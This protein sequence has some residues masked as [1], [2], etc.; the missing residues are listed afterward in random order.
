MCSGRSY[1]KTQKIIYSLRK[2]I[3]DIES[4]KINFSIINIKIDEIDWLNLSH[5]GHERM[6]ISFFKKETHFNWVA[7]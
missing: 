3:P 6:I 4:G 7:P 5:K 1:K 2:N